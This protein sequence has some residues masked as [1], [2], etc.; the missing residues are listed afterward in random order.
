MTE[1]AKCSS[2]VLTR[3][4]GNCTVLLLKLM[5]SMDMCSF[6]FSVHFAVFHKFL[7]NFF[8]KLEP[9]RYTRKMIGS[10]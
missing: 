7:R 1:E 9:V 10:H 2:L 5:D 8:S 4:M 3:R 6:K